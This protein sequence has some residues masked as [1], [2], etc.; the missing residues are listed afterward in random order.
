[1][2]MAESSLYRPVR[3]FLRNQ[4]FTVHAEAHHCDVAAHKGDEL[5]IVELKLTLSV[6]LLAQGVQRMKLSDTVYVAVPAPKTSAQLVRMKS[7]FPILRKLELGL[8]AVD[9][10]TGT[11]SVFVQPLPFQRRRKPQSRKA[12]LSELAGR[13]GDDNIGGSTRI[14][15]VTAYREN[16]VLVAVALRRL[17]PSRPKDLRLMGTGPK[18]LPILSSNYYGWFVR[19]DRGIYGL[20]EKGT[21]D[22]EVWKTL[23]ERKETLLATPDTPAASKK[24]AAK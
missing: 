24:K 11:V 16:A 18:T 3:D 22:L 10:S 6:E 5:V 21:A 20:T 17:G 1:M 15:I 19:L 7:F 9:I 2:S 4:G 8:L 14:K 23:A 12:L 13:S